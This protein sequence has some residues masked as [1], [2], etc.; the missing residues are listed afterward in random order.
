[1]FHLDAEVNS[2]LASKYFLYRR[3]IHCCTLWFTSPY[4]LPADLKH[5]RRHSELEQIHAQGRK[6]I[7]SLSAPAGSTVQVTRTLCAQSLKTRG[8]S[9]DDSSRLGHDTLLGGDFQG[10]G[11]NVL[12]RHVPSKRR[13]QLS[14]N[15]P[16][17][18]NL[19][20]QNSEHITKAVKDW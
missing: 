4:L 6:I 16:E 17:H 5:F 3:K 12:G 18:C 9:K 13:Y 19:H 14:I 2:V 10:R 1:L 11:S 20:Q 7:T 15:I 8:I